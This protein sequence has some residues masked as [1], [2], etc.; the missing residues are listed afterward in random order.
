MCTKLDYFGARYYMSDISVWNSVDAYA[1][2]YPSNSPYMY[3]LGNPVS[4]T[5]YQG[6]FVVKGTKE[7]K[8]ILNS[9]IKDLREAL[10]NEYIRQKFQLHSGLTDDEIM[11]LLSDDKRSPTLKF[12]NTEGDNAQTDAMANTKA[13]LNGDKNASQEV[14]ITIN[15]DFANN[16][17]EVGLFE[18]NFVTITILHEMVHIGDRKD[19]K[20]ANID[21]VNILSPKEFKRAKA[22]SSNYKILIEAGKAFEIDLVGFDTDIDNVGKAYRTLKRRIKR[23]RRR[24]KKKKNNSKHGTVLYL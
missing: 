14:V 18:S 1:A 5:D 15:K 9:F 7:E 2:M 12:D 23:H 17:Y 6:N 16:L 13:W 24:A 20:K 3:V 21:Y 22:A 11:F 10:K 4:N 19:G 8:R